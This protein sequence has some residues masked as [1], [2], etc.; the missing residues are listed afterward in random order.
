MKVL[1]IFILIVVLF[2]YVIRAVFRSIGRI[3]L[4]TDRSYARYETSSKTTN[5]KEGD[6]QIDRQRTE[7]KQIN[8]NVG[9]YVDYEEVK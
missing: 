7:E 4:G 9:E 5:R 3:L 8:A 1:V 2:F 6:V